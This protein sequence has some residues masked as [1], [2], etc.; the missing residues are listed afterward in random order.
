VTFTRKTVPKEILMKKKEILTLLLAGGRGTRLKKLTE[1]MA[2]PAVPF[3]GKYRIIDFALSNCRNS[4]MNTV[5][6]LTQYQPH[7]LQNYI[8]NGENWELNR[9]DSGITFLPPFQCDD[10]DR[11]YEG[12]AHAIAQ[13]RQYIQYH[14]PEYV[15]VISGDH[16]YKMDYNKLLDLHKRNAADVTISVTHV[17][18]DEASRYGVMNVDPK[19]KRILGF[20]E[21]PLIPQSN[22]ASMGIYIFNWHTL[23][24]IFE[25]FQDERDY[26]NDFGKDM[27]PFML[28]SNYRLFAYEFKGYWKDVGTVESYWEANM[29]L[30]SR[31]TNPILQQKDW[32]IFTADYSLPPTY[33]D[34]NSSF[35]ESLIGEG[36]EIYGDIQ[37]SVISYSVTIG[38]G[39]V[40]K[41]SVILPNTIIKENVEIKNSVINGNTIIDSNLKFNE[42]F[43]NILRIND[44]KILNRR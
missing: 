1:K 26:L 43:S 10:M 32:P 11:W 6:I 9:R 8:S 34:A 2:K 16:I 30:L 21:K 38:K 20:E 17:P 31:K 29:D 37:K 5:G 40:I 41:N 15:L 3:G 13:N 28:K 42:S 24:A 44:R 22:L 18:R 39:S 35:T 33:F 14:N 12:T 27:I 19:T 7:T 36:C 23:K 4:G 25:Q